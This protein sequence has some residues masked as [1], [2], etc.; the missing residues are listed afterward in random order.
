[1]L[2]ENG[3]MREKLGIDRVLNNKKQAVTFGVAACFVIVLKI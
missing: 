2:Y 1:M 3:V